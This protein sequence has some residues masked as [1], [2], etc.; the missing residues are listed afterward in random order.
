[1]ATKVSPKS[2]TVTIN[3]NMVLK[4]ESFRSSNTMAKTTVGQVS[5]RVMSIAA[6]SSVT[7]IA[8]FSTADGKGTYIA[9]DFKYARITNLDDTNFILI[10]MREVNKESIVK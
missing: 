1:M 9:D 7:E 8:N 2:G 10:V 6:G 5:K 3:E 4:G